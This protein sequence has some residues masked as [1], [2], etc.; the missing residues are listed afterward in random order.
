MIG[1]KE[2]QRSRSTLS[3]ISPVSD[4]ESQRC[5]NEFN[6][7]CRDAS[8][9][10]RRPLCTVFSYR[11]NSKLIGLCPSVLSNIVQGVSFAQAGYHVSSSP[12][13]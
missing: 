10:H 12:L 3:F 7:C 4:V 6:C 11:R 2:S 8:Y 1:F 5:I 13:L 9:E